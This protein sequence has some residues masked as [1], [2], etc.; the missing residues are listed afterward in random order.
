MAIG[1]TARVTPNEPRADTDLETCTT[2]VAKR[3]HRVVVVGGGFGGQLP[4]D[5]A[6]GGTA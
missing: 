3:R 2:L 1:Q 4:L 5:L 6:K